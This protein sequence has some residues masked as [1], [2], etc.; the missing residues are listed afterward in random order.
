ML[1]GLK[2]QELGDTH[3]NQVDRQGLKQ[4]YW[5]VYDM[6]GELKYQGN[7]VDGHPV[8]EFIYYYPTGKK[9]AEVRNLEQGWIRY[10]T[11]YHPDGKLMAEGK[12]VGQEKDS[13]WKYYS[14]LDASLA[15][16][17]HYDRGTPAGDWITYYPSGQVM[18][19]VTYKEGLKQGPWVQYFSDGSI[20]AEGTYK[21]DEMHGLFVLH[22][23]SG[24]VEVSGSYDEGKK[25]GTWV[26]LNEIGEMVKKEIYKNGTLIESEE[27]IPQGAQKR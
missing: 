7:Y 17:E 2:A 10:I 11:M 3:I 18:E 12:Y 9:Q 21:D 4:G 8:G 16:E 15:L 6:T 22:H 19:V 24:Q 5:K 14:S 26:H 1:F 23:I 20:K 13:T 27:F 25:V